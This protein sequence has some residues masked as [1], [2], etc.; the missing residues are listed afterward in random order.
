MDK[1][2]GL[3][4]QVGISIMYYNPLGNTMAISK[5]AQ[6]V[7]KQVALFSFQSQRAYTILVYNL[8]IRHEDGGSAPCNTT[9]ISCA[10][11]VN[12]GF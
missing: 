8:A 2:T 5:L 10:S 1:G 6:T 9:P 3:A 4:L 11:A 7:P 12:M